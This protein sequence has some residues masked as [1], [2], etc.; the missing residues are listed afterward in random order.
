MSNLWKLIAVAI[1]A[2]LV[3]CQWTPPQSGALE[4]A[5][6]AFKMARGDPLVAEAAPAELHDAQV[7]LRR[8]ERSWIETRDDAMTSHLAYVAYQRV[9]I[10]RN[11]GLQ[12]EAEQRLQR[13]RLEGGDLLAAESAHEAQAEGSARNLPPTLLPATTLSTA[14]PGPG[15]A[16]PTP[17]AVPP[18]PGAIDDAQAAPLAPAAAPARTAP[19]V[20][21]PAKPSLPPQVQARSAAPKRIATAR[22]K[23]TTPA[24]LR[25]VA[26]GKPLRKRALAARSAPEPDRVAVARPEVWYIEAQGR[27]TL[28]LLP[29]THARKASAVAELEPRHLRQQQRRM[30]SLYAGGHGQPE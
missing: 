20:L 30:Q 22:H 14:A 6:R 15:A 10:A 26:H 29:T 28:A 17:A 12:R 11:A 25:H 16:Q 4:E 19:A 27:P 1:G 7:A 9:A 5:R 3:A 21:A 23:I 13:A 24:P 8:A 2:V 18:A